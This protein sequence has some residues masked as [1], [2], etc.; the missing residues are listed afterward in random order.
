MRQSISG[1][2]F[3]RKLASDDLVDSSHF[4]ILM[5]LSSTTWRLNLGQPAKQ[6]LGKG[7]A[8]A[9]LRRGGGVFDVWQTPANLDSA[10]PCGGCW[11]GIA[12]WAAICNT[13]SGSSVLVTV[14]TGLCT[15][16][17]KLFGI[18]GDSSLYLLY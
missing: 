15:T 10:D 4:T 6:R 8:K 18:L 14:V 11:A 5:L 3:A 9:G 13:S 12:S 16:T 17:D 2:F 1:D 7:W